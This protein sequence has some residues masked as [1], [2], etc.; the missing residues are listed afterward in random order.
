MSTL[1]VD[2]LD[3]RTGSGNIT[4][5]RPLT[6]LSG[7]G[8]SLTAL[9][10]TELT[11]GTIPIARIADDAVT[12]AK[13]A[14]VAASKLSGTIADARIPGSAVTQHVTQYDDSSLR[15]DILNLALHQSI[16]DN[17]IAFNLDNSFVDGFEDDTGITTETNVDRD[18]SGEFVSTSSSGVGAYTSDSNTLLLLHCDGSDNGTTFT[19][20]SSHNRTA[21]VRNTVVTKT[22]IKKFGTASIYFGTSGAHGNALS[23]PDHND[24]AFGTNPFTIECWLYLIAS[25]TSGNSTMEIFNQATS[26]VSDASGGTHFNIWNSSTGTRTPANGV[27]RRNGS[28]TSNDWNSVSPTEIALNTWTHVAFTRESNTIRIYVGGVQRQTQTVDSFGSHTIMSN[29]HGGQMWISKR[30]YSNSYGFINGYIDEYRVSNNCRYP[31]GT[32]F[33]PGYGSITNA[34]GTLISDA[35]TA[36]SSRTSCSG[37]IM[38]ENQSGTA[39]LGTDLKIYFTANNGTNW[40]EASS[41]GTATTYSGGT[42]IVKLGATTVTAGTQVAMKA[43][44]ANQV[45]GSKV[46]RLHGWAVNY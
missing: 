2:T 35:Q 14:E 9:N 46:T 18:T 37:V 24:W 15:A 40:T 26:D 23:F 25:P 21:T 3:T 10:A 39:T 8:A 16:A 41:Y 33:T 43:V 42:K 44:W 22:G 17:R 11:S 7:S 29:N 5:S 1:K 6:G 4:V 20:S 30:A 27:Y 36:S 45:S 13:I 12:D 34:T 19:D 31:S 32:T 28:S 38:Y